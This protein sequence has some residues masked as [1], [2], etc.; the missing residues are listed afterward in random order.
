MTAKFACFLNT[1]WDVQSSKRCGSINRSKTHI[2]LLTKHLRKSFQKEEG[3]WFDKI[4]FPNKSILKAAKTQQL[5]T[6]VTS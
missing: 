4:E 2:K 5:T 6:K 1:F 3:Q